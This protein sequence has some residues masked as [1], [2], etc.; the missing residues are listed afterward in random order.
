MNIP[1]SLFKISG[2]QSV[3]Q[4]NNG[5]QRI[6]E[7]ISPDPIYDD[8]AQEEPSTSQEAQAPP[9]QS[10]TKTVTSS[11]KKRVVS[12]LNCFE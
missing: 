10:N 4:I 7:E 6:Y 1:G 8:V 9:T 11:T 3:D 2:S 12:F 5:D